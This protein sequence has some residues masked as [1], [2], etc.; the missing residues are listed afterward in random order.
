MRWDVVAMPSRRWRRNKCFPSDF[1]KATFGRIANANSNGGSVN[2][3]IAGQFAAAE[4]KQ[5]DPVDDPLDPLRKVVAN[6]LSWLS[7]DDWLKDDIAVE[8]G[9][10][11]SGAAVEVY[12]RFHHFRVISKCVSD[13]IA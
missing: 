6:G 8:I 1:D 3:S 7:L 12:E 2:V 11:S 5:R 4:D 10:I 13:S 9:N